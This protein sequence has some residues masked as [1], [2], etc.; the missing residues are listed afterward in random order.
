VQA[1][2]SKFK[3]RDIVSKEA[4]LNKGKRINRNF[5]TGMSYKPLQAKTVEEHKRKKLLIVCDSS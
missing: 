4:C 5:L 1:M 3:P 2:R